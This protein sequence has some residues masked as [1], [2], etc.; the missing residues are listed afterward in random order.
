MR[1]APP[2]TTKST[3]RLL[4]MPAA[5]PQSTATWPVVTSG[6]ASTLRPSQESTGPRAELT[7][8]TKKPSMAWLT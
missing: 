8:P 2:M 6:V 7:M 5:T 4:A 3:T 1:T